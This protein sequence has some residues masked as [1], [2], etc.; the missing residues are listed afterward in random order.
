[1]KIYMNVKITVYTQGS[2]IHSLHSVIRELLIEVWIKS[3]T[4]LAYHHITSDAQ[5]QQRCPWESE[6]NLLFTVIQI[7]TSESCITLL[8]LI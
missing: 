7:S 1:M 6:F 5:R 3:Y 2:A 8:R 4:I